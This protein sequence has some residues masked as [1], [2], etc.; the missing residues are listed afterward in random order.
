MTPDTP[1][2]EPVVCPTCTSNKRNVCFMLN[3]EDH[4][5]HCPDPWHDWLWHDDPA[6]CCD[7][8]NPP[9]YDIE[10]V[11]C[12]NCPGWPKSV[13]NPLRPAPAEPETCPKCKGSGNIPYP[14][15]Y[16]RAAILAA[17]EAECAQREA[18]AVEAALE[19]LL[20][21]GTIAGQDE[22]MIPARHVHTQLSKLRASKERDSE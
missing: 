1:A 3:E 4:N 2:A 12:E 16:P 20:S 18:R 21:V 7:F 13:S 10:E 5:T 6:P 17:H 8:H 11:C 19:S 22:V 15:P 9:C 14:R